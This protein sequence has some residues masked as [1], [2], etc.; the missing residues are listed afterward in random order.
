MG[1]QTLFISGL[2]VFPPLSGGQK[3]SAAVARQLSVNSPVVV[4]SLTGRKKE[5]LSGIASSS[6]QVAPELQRSSIDRSFSGSC[7]FLPIG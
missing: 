5:Y 6:N 7:N 4:Y 3:R 2:Q 1:K